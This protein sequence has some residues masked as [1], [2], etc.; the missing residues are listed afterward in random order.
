MKKI[1]LAIALLL[2]ASAGYSQEQYLTLTIKSDKEA[3]EVGEPI[4]LTAK[5]VNSGDHSITLSVRINK[6]C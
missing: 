6:S 2:L 3:Y 4:N 1:A 5:F